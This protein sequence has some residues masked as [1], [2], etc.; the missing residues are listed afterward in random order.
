[1]PPAWIPR[2]VIEMFEAKAAAQKETVSNLPP[3]DEV[4]P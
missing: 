1:V 4:A 3:L 2:D